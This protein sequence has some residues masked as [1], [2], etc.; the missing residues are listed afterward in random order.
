MRHALRTL[1]VLALALT[2]LAA[3]QGVNIVL[4]DGSTCKAVGPEVN[5]SVAGGRVSHFCNEGVALVGDLLLEDET[6]L[7]TRITYDPA[8]ARNIL[9]DSLVALEV[10]G[11]TLADGTECLHAGFGATLAIDGARANYTCGEDTV[12]LGYF[13]N[14]DQGVYAEK[15]T[16]G[17]GPGGFTLAGKERVLVSTLDASSP[18]TNVEWHLVSFGTNGTPALADSPA[19][20]EIVDGQAVGTTGCNRYF[21]AVE[22]GLDGLV[23]FGP[24]GST[25]MYCEGAMDQEQRFLA[26]LAGVTSFHM[27]ADGLLVLGGSDGDLL[28]S[29]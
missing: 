27:T 19:T 9:D 4:P 29:R 10:R 1:I 15:A 11:V 25:M 18:I 8:D 3:A 16:I 22:F 28:F 17:H 14:T 21:A 12:I 13:E 7:V 6:G 5:V 2:G 26:T 20:L 24:A 23:G